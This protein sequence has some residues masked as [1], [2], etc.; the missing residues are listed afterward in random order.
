MGCLKSDVEI[1]GTTATRKATTKQIPF[2][3]EKQEV[4]HK[5]NGNCVGEMAGDALVVGGGFAAY[6]E[7]ADEE[8][9]G[10]GQ[11]GD[12]AYEAEAVH[13]G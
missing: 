3:D 2:G 13:E 8:E 7:G 11:E 12:P 6:F 9:D 4:N 10:D 5:S 1:F